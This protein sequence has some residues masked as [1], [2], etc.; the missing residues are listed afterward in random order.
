[1]PKNKFQDVIY[2][3]IMATI[4][5]YGMIVYNVALGMGGVKTETFLAAFHELPIMAPIGIPA[6]GNDAPFCNM[7]TST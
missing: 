7:P 1:M 3:A 4:M 5:V 6:N 2:T